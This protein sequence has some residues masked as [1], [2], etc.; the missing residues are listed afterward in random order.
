[1]NTHSTEKNHE[2]TMKMHHPY[3]GTSKDSE[4]RHTADAHCPAAPPRGAQGDRAPTPHPPEHTHDLRPRD[5]ASREA[6][7]P[8]APE[9]ARECSQQLVTAR[10]GPQL[11]SVSRGR[12]ESC[13]S[14]QGE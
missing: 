11:V 3:A 10:N 2:R 7:V 14:W 8:R 6:G 13:P 12:V 1:M 4:T 9:A 5:S